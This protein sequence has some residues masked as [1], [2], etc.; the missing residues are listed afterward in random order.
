MVLSSVSCYTLGFDGEMKVGGAG[1]VVF[2]FN[3]G[4]GGLVADPS[5]G[6]VVKFLYSRSAD[7]HVTTTM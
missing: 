2:T 1:G 4:D 6:P 3:P 7:S 5:T